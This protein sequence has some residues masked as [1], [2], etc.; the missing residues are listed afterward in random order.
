MECPECK[1]EHINKN[2]QKKGK[3]NYICVDCHKQFINDYEHRGYA[4]EIK[5][6]CLSMYLNGMG[7]RAIQR[8]KGIHNTT[9][10]NWVKQVREILPDNC[11][12]A[13][14]TKV[15]ALADALQS[16]T[17][18]VEV[19]QRRNSLREGFA[20]DNEVSSRIM[21]DKTRQD[22]SKT[23]SDLREKGEQKRERASR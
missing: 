11:D 9:I 4:K 15:G 2:G 23:L 14:T 18:I 21:G 5:Q 20:N 17:P 1:S 7:F 19:R 12:P 8:V 16:R 3:Q 13:R 22:R 6:E 10:R